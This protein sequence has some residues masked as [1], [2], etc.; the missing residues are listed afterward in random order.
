MSDRPWWDGIDDTLDIHAFEREGVQRLV[1]LEAVA[2]AARALTDLPR[3]AWEDG[4]DGWYALRDL[5]GLVAR[6][7]AGPAAAP[8]SGER[9]P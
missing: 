8:S 5:G 7:D 6:L 9:G 4:G 2:A 1:N 3:Q